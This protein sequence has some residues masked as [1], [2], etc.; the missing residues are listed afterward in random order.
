[1][2]RAVLHTKDMIGV[3][4]LSVFVQI[5]VKAVEVLAV[6]KLDLGAELGIRRRSEWRA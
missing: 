1:M 2:H 5:S 3:I 6:E 4:V